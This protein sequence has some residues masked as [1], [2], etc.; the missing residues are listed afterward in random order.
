MFYTIGEVAKKTGVPASTLRYYDKE[1]LLPFVERSGGG[2][3]V[4]GESDI[5]WLRILE[6]LKKSGLSLSEIKDYIRMMNE[7]D[8]TI[9]ERLQLFCRR[10]EM[11]EVQ[12]RNLG[13]T[14]AM[15]NYKCWYYETAKARGSVNAMADITEADIPDELKPTWERLK[16]K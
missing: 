11:L 16:N 15:I 14:L 1:G 13:E 9:D 3:R 4:F 6:C 8:E 12:M 10:R 5:E 2:I 7:G